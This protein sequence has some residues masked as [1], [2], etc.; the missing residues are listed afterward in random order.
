M[1]SCEDIVQIEMQVVGTNFISSYY[2]QGVL[3]RPDVCTTL[4]LSLRT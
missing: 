2:A 3:L 4:D 1:H